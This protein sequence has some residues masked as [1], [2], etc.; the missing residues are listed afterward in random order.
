MDE[1]LSLL[2]TSIKKING[3]IDKQHQQQQVIMK[4]IEWIISDNSSSEK[5]IEGSVSHTKGKGTELTEVTD[6][7][8]QTQE[9]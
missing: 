9:V 1:N 6:E 7:L 5:T 8:K 4:C 3:Q 2:T